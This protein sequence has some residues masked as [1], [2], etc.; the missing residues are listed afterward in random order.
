MIVWNHL[1]TD[2]FAQDFDDP[3]SRAVIWLHICNGQASNFNQLPD[4]DFDH[5]FKDGADALPY[6]G[7]AR[8]AELLGL[9]SLTSYRMKT[10]T[11]NLT[12][13]LMLPGTVISRK[14]SGQPY[15]IK[16]KVLPRRT[17]Q[18][19]DILRVFYQK[20]ASSLLH[21]LM[22]IETLPMELDGPIAALE[23]R[24]DQAKVHIPPAYI[25][26]HAVQHHGDQSQSWV[27]SNGCF[28]KVVQLY[29][30][31]FDGVLSNDR[32]VK[33]PCASSG[34]V[35]DDSYNQHNVFGPTMRFFVDTGGLNAGDSISLELLQY[36]RRI[37][38]HGWLDMNDTNTF[39]MNQE[40]PQRLVGHLIEFCRS[41]LDTIDRHAANYDIENQVGTPTWPRRHPGAAPFI[42][43]FGRQSEKRSDD[44]EGDGRA[45]KRH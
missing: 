19:D 22:S 42:G 29:R 4:E 36:I 41:P 37:V 43:N 31:R 17:P 10:L 39:S 26:C 9:T 33:L 44:N 21:P 28:V 15:R 18:I 1:G 16:K 8:H 7:K 20:Y 12:M 24:P 30:S 5:Q 40:I 23:H 35:L 6:R 34:F 27:L 3:E 11:I 38:K 14:V 32:L 13:V 45:P 25:V 2:E